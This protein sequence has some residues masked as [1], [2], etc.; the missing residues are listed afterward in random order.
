LPAE[1]RHQQQERIYKRMKYWTDVQY[2]EAKKARAR[3]L[4]AAKKAAREA[5]DSSSSVAAI[6]RNGGD[7][8][9]TVGYADA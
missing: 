7:A 6:V 1:A 5:K 4:Y 9:A 3:E 8:L 2:R